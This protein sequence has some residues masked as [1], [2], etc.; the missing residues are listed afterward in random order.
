MLTRVSRQLP[1]R[2]G[3]GWGLFFFFFFFLGRTLWRAIGQRKWAQSGGEGEINDKTGRSRDSFESCGG[4]LRNCR[5]SPPHSAAGW[6]CCSAPRAICGA[7]VFTGNCYGGDEREMKMSSSQRQISSKNKMGVGEPP[8]P[9]CVSSLHG[10]EYFRSYRSRD[11]GSEG[12]SRKFMLH[13]LQRTCWLQ[14]ESRQNFPSNWKKLQYP[15]S[16]GCF[17]I[18]ACLHK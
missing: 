3:L 11:F 1:A 18:S 16:L 15:Q 13:A 7:L 12:S 9:F 5:S 8:N 6:G 2:W 17:R 4:S 10:E 14:G